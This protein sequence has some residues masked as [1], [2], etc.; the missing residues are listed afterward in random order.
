MAQSNIL[1]YWR[2]TSP[3]SN[4]HLAPQHGPEQYIL[5]HRRKTSPMSNKHLAAQHGPEQYTEVLEGDITNESLKE[6]GTWW[7]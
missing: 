7:P 6:E 2:K 5:K 1:K 4:I 3:M